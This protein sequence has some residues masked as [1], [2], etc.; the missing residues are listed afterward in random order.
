M[1][2]TVAIVA[3]CAGGARAGRARH[4]GRGRPPVGGQD[5]LL[6]P[7]PHQPLP[8]HGIPARR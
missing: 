2:G 5:V 4:P 6:V 8:H 3:H 7:G 1:N